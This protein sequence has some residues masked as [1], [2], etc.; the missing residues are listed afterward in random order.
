MSAEAE[1][2]QVALD[3][4]RRAVGAI[5]VQRLRAE[6]EARRLRARSGGARG[7]TDLAELAR[8]HE[9]RAAR[10]GEQAD[11]LRAVADRAEV[12]LERARL[13]DLDP[14]PARPTDGP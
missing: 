13:A 4:A 9:L 7:L 5:G 14:A 10:L 11:A 6:R 12:A 1:A 8:T 3:D 2:A